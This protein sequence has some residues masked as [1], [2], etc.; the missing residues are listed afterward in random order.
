MKKRIIFSI[1]F[2]LA[3]SLHAD[4][5]PA[6]GTARTVR[7]PDGTELRIVVSGDEHCRIV[8]TEDG[9]AVT[10]GNDGF[11]YYASYDLAGVKRSTGVRVTKSNGASAAANAAR[12]IP[13]GMLRAR[14]AQRRAEVNR[15]RSKH[16][17]RVSPDTKAGTSVKKGLV[18]L[19]QF[20]DLKFKFG[21]EY[22][23]NMLNQHGYSFAGATGS[24]LDYFN[25]QFE[26]AASFEFAV[27]SIVTLSK[28]YA[29]YG[30]NDDEDQDKR[31][32]EAVIEACRLVDAEI[33]F[34]Q[35]DSDGDGEVDNVF[36]FVP[37]HDE[38]EGAGENHIW[39]HQW[40]FDEAGIRL[41]LDGT[42]IN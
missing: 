26:G 42:K 30:E 18:I 9:S 6:R 25:D 8:R 20:T 38:A 7:Q 22:F 11:W 16:I 37:G 3:A 13:Y 31:P 32:H 5:I 34:S 1:L 17:A 27:S 24:A 41:N 33:D 29:Y 2:L 36:V 14:G 40:Y 19:A 39:S 23:A 10:M 35:Y 28:G 4:A 15:V 21:R 12:A